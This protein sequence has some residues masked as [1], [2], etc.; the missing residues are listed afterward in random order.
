LFGHLTGSWLAQYLAAYL[1][2]WWAWL[3]ICLPA[4]LGWLAWLHI[5]LAGWLGWLA[6]YALQM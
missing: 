2:G 1:L 6:G 4:W 3:P 5:F